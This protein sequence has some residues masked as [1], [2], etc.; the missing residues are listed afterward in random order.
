M[1]PLAIAHIGILVADVETAR[2]NWAKALGASFSQIVRYRS[3]AW[4]GI[5]DP[6]PHANDLRQTIYVGVNP[7]IEIQEFVAN[8]SHSPS[9]GEGGHHLSFPPVSDNNERRRELAT[10]GIGMAGGANHEGRWIIQFSDPQKLNNVSTEWV[11]ESE[12]HLDLKDDG[13][14]IDRLPDGSATIF[15]AETT[16]TFGA[17][18][19]QSDI[20]EFGV[21]VADLGKAIET[22]SAVT[23]YAFDAAGNGGR[24]AVTR[25]MVPAVRLV[26]AQGNFAREG[27]YCAVVETKSIDETIERLRS[28]KVPFVD[29]SG[30]KVSVDPAYLNGFSLQ[31]VS[32][33]I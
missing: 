17:H 22:W 3:T 1:E 19:P 30:V 28:A 7:S 18:R 23:G 33:N 32:A 5:A 6:V 31:F 15:D 29:E 11:E 27:L 9:R 12:G 16:R 13:S 26:E 24:S 8:G 10:L 20:V 2:R 4:S 25:G 21:L 14:P